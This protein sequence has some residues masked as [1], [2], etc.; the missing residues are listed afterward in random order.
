SLDYRNASD[1]AASYDMYNA[2]AKKFVVDTNGRVILQKDT[3]DRTSA[4]SNDIRVVKGGSWQD[5][6]YWLDPGQ[7]R[8]KNQSA[9]Y[10]WIGFRVAQDARVSDKARTR[11]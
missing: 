7:R 1:S 11:R 2:P 3:K 4:I 10:G 9:G 5:S 6:A 8:Y